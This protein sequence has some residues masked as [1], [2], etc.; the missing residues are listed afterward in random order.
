M[1]W[2]LFKL[3]TM[4]IVLIYCVILSLGWY[5]LFMNLLEED[6]WD[7]LLFYF[8]I[9]LFVIPGYVVAIVGV[10]YFVYKG[11][12]AFIFDTWKDFTVDVEP[13]DPPV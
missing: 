6:P 8:L 7:G 4:I 11:F 13:V 2:N 5:S 12:K 10:I 3:Y 9:F 1:P